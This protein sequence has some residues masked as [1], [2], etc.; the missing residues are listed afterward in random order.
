MSSRPKGLRLLEN[1]ITPEEEVMLL[2]SINWAEENKNPNETLKNRK[3]K[4]FGYEFRY[5]NNKVDIDKPIEPIPEKYTFLQRLFNENDC[6]EFEY[7]QLTINRYQAGQGM[8]NKCLIYSKRLLL[9][10]K[11]YV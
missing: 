4:H 9:D 2:E 1:F 10:W 6:G 7:D 5:D 3:V 11:I 8:K